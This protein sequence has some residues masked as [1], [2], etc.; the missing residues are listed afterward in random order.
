MSK[1]LNF[2]TW[3]EEQGVDT[4]LFW[5]NCKKKH[6]KWELCAPME[7][8]ELVRYNPPNWLRAAFSWEKSLIGTYEFL[9]LLEIKWLGEVEKYNIED[10]EFGFM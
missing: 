6:Q 7:R 3:L 2:K 10:I 5:K 8:R 9:F 4:K 1:K